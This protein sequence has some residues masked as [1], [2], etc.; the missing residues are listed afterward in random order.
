MRTLR[1]EYAR[2]NC[3]L[4]SSIKRRAERAASLLGQSITA[5][6]ETALA[7]KAEEVLAR[8]DRILLS[9][10][11]FAAFVRAIENPPPPTNTLRKAA[12]QY[13]KL[14][15]AQPAANW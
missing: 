10:H 11:D 5:F 7:E 3:R 12:A 8:R 1:T 15:R 6:T 9:E 2:L 14:K 4:N 13:I